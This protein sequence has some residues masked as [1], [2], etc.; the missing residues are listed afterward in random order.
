M[1]MRTSQRF[2]PQ[3]E[4]LESRHL[5]SAR[6][7]VFSKTAGFRHDSIADGIA[8]VRQIGAESGFDVDATEDANAFSDANLAQYHAVVFLLTTGDVLNRTQ[9]LAFE[10]YIQAGGGYAGVHSAAD[11]EY[12]WAWYGQLLGAYFQSHPAIQNA[13]SHIEDFY[14]PSTLQTPSPWRRN[15][16]WYNYRTNPRASGAIV[17]ARLDEST[18]QGGTMGADHPITWYKW[19]DGGRSWYTGMGHTRQSYQEPAF[20]QHL[21]GGLRFAI[22]EP[23]YLAAF[24]VANQ[25]DLYWTDFSAD[26]STVYYLARSQ[27]GINYDVVA[28]IA[29]PA[30]G[31]S[32]TDVTPATWYAY[33]LW[34]F[35]QG[36]AWQVSNFVWAQA[37][38]GDGAPRGGGDSGLSFVVTL[39]ALNWPEADREPF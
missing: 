21:A 26:P 23:L 24:P 19:F 34:S 39:L 20:R 13:D 1:K 27:D 15:D 10:R 2:R 14:H 8:T 3:V 36:G 6:V 9:E 30:Y 7:L 12:G 37:P 22:G 18:Y 17:L 5:L 31:Y 4:C 25:L 11:T 16:E 32:D 28:S 38:G 35:T 33:A 29:A